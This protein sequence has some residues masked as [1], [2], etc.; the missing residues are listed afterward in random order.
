MSLVTMV[1]LAPGL[2]LSVVAVGLRIRNR[3]VRGRPTA[4]EELRV[5]PG[6]SVARDAVLAGDDRAG[7]RAIAA[8]LVDLDARRLIAIRA[9]E[10]GSVP[11][12][13][14]VDGALLTGLDAAIV[15]AY[16]G[17][18]IVG[19]PGRRVPMAALGT[20]RHRRTRLAAVISMIDR[21]LE[22][23]GAARMP[24]RW[25]AVVIAL[26]AVLG[27][28]LSVLGLLVFIDEP[29][30]LEVC[31]AGFAMSLVALLVVPMRVRFPLPASARRRRELA[32][33]RAVVRA[34]GPSGGSPLAYV[35]VF[36]RRSALQRIGIG[37]DSVS[38]SDLARAADP[39]SGR[40]AVARDSVDLVD[41][42]SIL[43]P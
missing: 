12:I 1:V 5:V 30:R 13:E 14:I 27:M 35:T 36:G 2:A 42:V 3:L 26:L 43:L 33:A 18:T 15:S 9:A 37:P 21:D 41:G 31:A 38:L 25:P 34:E 28:V 24:A 29:A 22:K 20:R 6:T 19:I 10:R 17:C 16:T 23:S 40:L 7:R 32:T 8:A 11:E 4:A 39:G